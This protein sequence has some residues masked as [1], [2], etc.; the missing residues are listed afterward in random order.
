VIHDHPDMILIPA[1]RCVADNLVHEINRGGWTYT[2]NNA[3]DFL[4]L[5]HSSIHHV[6]NHN[7]P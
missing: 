7:P 5:A 4:L 3:Q 1:C 2:A 6:I